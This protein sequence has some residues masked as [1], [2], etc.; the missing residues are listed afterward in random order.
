[1]VSEQLI[2]A[3]WVKEVYECV[4]VWGSKS[5][6]QI[7]GKNCKIPW[8]NL[9]LTVWNNA[10]LAFL[11]TSGQNGNPHHAESFV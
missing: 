8:A 10:C 5:T 1:M 7:V 4:C 11:I 9:G 2:K 3:P 6:V